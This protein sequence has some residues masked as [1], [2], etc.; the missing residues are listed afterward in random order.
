MRSP[1]PCSPVIRKWSWRKTQIEKKCEKVSHSNTHVES[2]N[3]M[4]KRRTETKNITY[5]CFWIKWCWGANSMK[6]TSCVRKDSSNLSKSR[7]VYFHHS[8]VNF[9]NLIITFWN[10]CVNVC[11]AKKLNWCCV[12]FGT[13]KKRFVIRNPESLNP[14]LLDPCHHTK[15]IISFVN[16]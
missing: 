10:I 9:E 2:E 11:L 12:W 16:C 6:K 3:Q 5:L 14:E 7:F 1:F 13:C 4:P 15:W 8:L